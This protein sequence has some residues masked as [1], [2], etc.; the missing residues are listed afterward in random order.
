MDVKEIGCVGVNWIYVAQHRDCCEHLY[1]LFGSI[2][3][4]EVPDCVR[5][6]LL[7]GKDSPPHGIGN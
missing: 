5:I 2:K 3:C 6:C 1:K 4:R 7:L